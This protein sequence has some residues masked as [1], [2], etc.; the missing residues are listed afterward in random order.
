MHLYRHSLRHATWMILAVWLFA[1]GAGVANACLLNESNNGSHSF[2]V[3]M[4]QDVPV[5]QIHHG[6]QSAPDDAGCLK[7]CDE[8]SLAITKVDQPISDGS[9]GW[10]GVLHRASVSTLASEAA[11]HR[12][13]HATRPAHMALPI[14]A[15]PHRLTL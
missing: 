7:F 5:A 13:V 14:D 12:R 10:V 15:R 9:S 8:A 6:K 2:I 4:P 11:L 3:A 1:L